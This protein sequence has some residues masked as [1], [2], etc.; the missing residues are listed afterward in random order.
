M[1]F[2]TDASYDE[3][4]KIAGWGVVKEHHGNLGKPISNFGEFESIN[5]A[6]LFAIYQAC[7]LA[8]G[9]QA[10]IVT[11]SQSALSYIQKTVKDK[12]RTKE[13]HIRHKRCEFW[14]YKIRKFKNCTFSKQKAHTGYYQ[15][16]SIGNEIADS[17]A[18]FGRAKFYER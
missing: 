13:Q 6:E 16:R 4:R 10:E 17:S 8:G 11:D 12:E 5:E 18:R 3:K 9:S 1:I 15:T 2:Y 14:A 7:I